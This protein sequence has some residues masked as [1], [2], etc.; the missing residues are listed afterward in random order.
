MTGHLT[1]QDMI[2]FDRPGLPA[3]L[4]DISF[5]PVDNDL[6][7]D[8]GYSIQGDRQLRQ[9][10]AFNQVFAPLND[11]KD[12]DDPKNELARQM[13]KIDLNKLPTLGPYDSGFEDELCEE[14]R[15]AGQHSCAAESAH[16]G[17]RSGVDSEDVIPY[18]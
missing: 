7:Y 15:C 17:L 5:G 14:C 13:D 12:P 4:D 6:S 18:T 1:T 11:I 3:E 10:S 8:R 2:S 9:R 16:R